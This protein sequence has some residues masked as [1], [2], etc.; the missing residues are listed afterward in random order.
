MVVCEVPEARLS[1]NDKTRQ[2]I[3]MKS[4]SI[5]NHVYTFVQQVDKL[6]HLLNWSR[7]E[8]PSQRLGEEDAMS[9]TIVVKHL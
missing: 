4:I 8:L 3:Q 7:L 1:V 9:P 6:D 5:P 2:L